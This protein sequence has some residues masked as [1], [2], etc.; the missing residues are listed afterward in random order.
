MVLV[1]AGVVDTGGDSDDVVVG[2][3][4]E[5][6]AARTSATTAARAGRGAL[7]ITVPSCPGNDILGV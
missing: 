4:E 6:H 3:A 2:S 5:V 7:S 1:E